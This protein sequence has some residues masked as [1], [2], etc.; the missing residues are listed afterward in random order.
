MWYYKE[1]PVN[2]TFT[3][4]ALLHL[5]KKLSCNTNI[6]NLK[7]CEMKFAF[8]VYINPLDSYAHGFVTIKPVTKVN[9]AKF[10]LLTPEY[11]CVFKLDR[12]I[13]LR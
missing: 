7:A 11:T 8:I 9:T 4:A 12:V 3:I 5:T 10:T 2:L 13:E 1:K 6:A